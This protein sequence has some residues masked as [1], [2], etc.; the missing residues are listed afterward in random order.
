MMALA[1][2]YFMF[3]IYTKNILTFLAR[4]VTRDPIVLNTML[5]NIMSR[6]FRAPFLLMAT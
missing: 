1:C 6:T 3:L 5:K 4:K 2:I